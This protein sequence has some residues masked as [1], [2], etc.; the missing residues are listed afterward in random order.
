MRSITSRATLIG[1]LLRFDAAD[2]AAAERSAVHDRGVQF[3]RARA[4]EDGA[5]AGVEPRIVFQRD[6]DFLD[7]IESR[8]P[9]VRKNILPDGDRGPQRLLE[10]LRVLPASN[11]GRAAGAAVQHNDPA[12]C[13][14]LS[15][16]ACAARGRAH[17]RQ[18]QSTK[19]AFCNSSHSS[20]RY[21]CMTCDGI[22]VGQEC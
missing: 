17:Q 2:R 9:P 5:F 15:V 22:E 12:T 11:R 1:V 3:V 19:I 14:R 6:D 10:R 8:V 21:L 7:G 18:T 16:S 4:G 20:T 13:G